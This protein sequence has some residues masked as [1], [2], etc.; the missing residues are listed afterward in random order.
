MNIHHLELFYYVARHGGITEAVRNIPYGIQQPAVSGQ[1]AQLEEYLGVTLF[2]RRP[3]TLTPAGE[4]LYRFIEPFFANLDVVAGELQ[5]GKAR[6]I[7]IGATRIVLREHLPE[8]F[9][10]VRKR[11]PNLRISLREGYP[12]EFENLLQK[13]ELDLAVTAIEKKPAAGLHSVALV[14]LPLVL[15]VEKGNRI[16]AADQLWQRD[17]IEESLI[18]LPAAEVI[19]KNFQQGLTRLGVDWFPSL[20]VS[21]VDLIETY[22]ANG[23]GIGVSVQ[24]PKAKAAANVRAIPLPDFAPV[25]L[26]VLWRGKTSALLQAF[27]D[28]LQLRAKRFAS[29]E[30]LQTP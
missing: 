12:Q 4:K 20:E 8:V 16:A 19:T 27:L 5:G 28:E 9:Q 17:K 24:V 2:Q 3:F 25:V 18:C 13:G 22:V 10:T 30:N 26:G 23:F 14:E 1:V 29:R 21:S 7:R 15:L 11:F 6:Q